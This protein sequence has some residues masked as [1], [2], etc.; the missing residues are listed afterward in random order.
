MGIHP[1]IFNKNIYEEEG[2]SYEK[3]KESKGFIKC[4]DRGDVGMYVV[5]DGIGRRRKCREPEW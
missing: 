2:G 3:A 5:D 4:P 1:F